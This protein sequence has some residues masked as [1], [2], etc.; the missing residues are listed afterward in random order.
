MWIG[1]GGLAAAAVLGVT[2]FALLATPG[3]PKNCHFSCIRP[4]PGAPVLSPAVYHN[5]EFGYSIG[6]LPASPA[7]MA[8]TDQTSDG[9]TIQ[10]S[11]DAGLV[12]AAARGTNDNA[13][14]SAAF[15]SINTARFQQLQPMG[16]VRGAE[17]GMVLGTGFVYQ[18]YYVPPSGAQAEAISLLVMAATSNGLTIDVVA[19]SPHTSDPQWAPYGFAASPV[20]D[21]PITMTQFS[22][23]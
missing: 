23:G 17:V 6:Y 8:L 19:Y 7:P 5:A 18:G 12:F 16:P 13:A 15:D 10:L 4:E 9:V 21:Y 11:G 14:V 22:G 3:T 20:L 2:A 1:A